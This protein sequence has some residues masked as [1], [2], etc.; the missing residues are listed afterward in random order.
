M[1][2]HSLVENELVEDDKSSVWVLKNHNGFDYSD[3]AGAETYLDR[4]L[5]SAK[6]LG[7]RSTELASH[8]RDWTSE[9]HLSAK[10]GQLISGFTF[11]RSLKVLEVGSGCGAISRIL[12]ESFDRVV[13]IEGSLARARLAQLRTRDLASVSIICAPFHKIR[14]AE[15]FD[16][17][18]CIGVYEYSAAFVEAPDPY[19]EVLRRFADA[20]TPDGMVVIAIENQFGL[21]YFNGCREDHLGT[22]FEGI[23]GYHRRKAKVRTFGKVEL[24]HRLKSHFQDV[25]FFYP[26]PDYKLP[27][28]VLSAE[29]LAAEAAGEL[30]S[31]MHSRDYAGLMRP[32]WDEAATVLELARNN[33]LEHFANSFLVLAGR[34]GLKGVAFNQLAILYSSGRT[35]KF[36]TQ[37]QIMSRSERWVVSKRSLQSTG[38]V[39]GGVVRLVNVETPWLNTQSLDTQVMLRSRS[40]D[41]TLEE[42]FAPCRAWFDML[43]AIS[44]TR[45]GDKYLDGAH[46][47]SIWSNVYADQS[48]LKIIDREWL[49]HADIPLNVIV[50]RAIYDFL[51]RLE[52]IPHI[53]AALNFRS[54]RT[55]IRRIAIAIGANIQRHDFDAFIALESELQAVVCGRDRSSQRA[56]S[57]W[58]L[59]DRTSLRQFRR[60][61][62]MAQSI[63]A[64]VRA[65]LPRGT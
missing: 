33:I 57:W 41:L 8:V 24:E 36:T 10:R 5:R 43:V 28:C 40:D 30:V 27:D 26:Y 20:L 31:Q 52:R 19:D 21:K 61:M 9:Y 42:I 58:F 11:D 56:F 39:D 17:I 48:G 64:R 38:A 13:C 54:G 22:H 3:G 12:G 50:I 25:H 62:K 16:V 18:F 4:V 59:V 60:F 1:S 37:T 65:R 35:N 23:E 7:S 6:D 45:D 14:F 53:G 2:I 15:K 49:W 51:L 63:I 47:D 44:K 29:F 55:L 32:F 34:S 46:V